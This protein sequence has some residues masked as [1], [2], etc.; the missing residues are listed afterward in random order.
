MAE[1]LIVVSFLL[2]LCGIFFLIGFAI[3]SK[4]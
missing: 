2:I 4:E 1:I 3:G